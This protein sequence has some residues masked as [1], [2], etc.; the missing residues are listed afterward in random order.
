[1]EKLNLVP[2]R[3]RYSISNLCPCG[4]SNK[5][6]K[7]SPDKE[8]P[9][10]GYCHSCDKSFFPKTEK[11][12]IIPKKSEIKKTD[13]IDAEVMRKSLTGYDKNNFTQSIKKIYPEIDI[14]ARAKTAGIGTSKLW[15]G[16]TIF[17]QI[18]EN[19]KVRSGKI[20][21][22]DPETLKRVKEP[23]SHF[24]WLHSVLKLKDF[25]L[26]QCLFGLHLVKDDG[27]PIALIESEKTAF[28]MSLE[29]DSYHWL[30]TGG[31]SNFKYE[32]LAPI[33]GKKIIAFPDKGEYKYWLD[34]SERLTDFGFDI[35]ISK[36]IEDGEF[37]TGTDLADLLLEEK[38]KKAE[39][40]PTEPKRKSYEE[41][42]RQ[43]RLLFGLKH[44]KREELQEL[45]DEIF[46][47][48]REMKSQPLTD[49]L[50]ISEGLNP[51]DASDILDLFCI[52]KILNVTD[53]G[54]I[55]NNEK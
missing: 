37:S 27:K 24:N 11:P 34:I 12:F 26:S 38:Q 25:N 55:L 39:T 28:L 48:C 47:N 22:Y 36:T 31:K 14:E 41:Y 1:M 42:T 52:H 32:T 17:F 3:L 4:K 6:G 29:N 53:R 40:E 44:F 43:E 13:F 20:M 35:T 51:T 15:N 50:L 19:N 21:L 45:A 33:K 5:D 18:D 7:F 23:F 46:L 49:S 9:E 8:D 10:C 54:Y 16:A 2:A 30:A